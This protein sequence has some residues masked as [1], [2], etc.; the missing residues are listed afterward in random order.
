M[1]KYFVGSDGDTPERLYFSLEDAI[2][3]AHRYIDSFDE[4]GNRVKGRMRDGSGY[5]EDF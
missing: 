4:A 2:N 1:E 5:T 3:G